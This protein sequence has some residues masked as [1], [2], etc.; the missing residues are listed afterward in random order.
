MSRNKFLFNQSLLSP[1]FKENSQNI[2]CTNGH[3]PGVQPASFEGRVGKVPISRA[4]FE[5]IIMSLFAKSKNDC[6]AVRKFSGSQ[7]LRNVCIFVE[8][9]FPVHV[10]EQILREFNFAVE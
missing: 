1:Q 5:L 4:Q 10:L 8:L 2:F 3:L 7:K 9:N 6:F